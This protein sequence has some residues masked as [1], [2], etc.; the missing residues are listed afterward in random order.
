MGYCN[1]L[2]MSVICFE[3]VWVF[4]ILHI[5]ITNGRFIVRYATLFMED[6]EFDQMFILISAH[7]KS[8]V[9]ESALPVD[10]LP[11]LICQQT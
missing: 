4:C 10:F 9:T 2:T 7:Y 11:P 1:L 5:L 8:I 6:K 3:I